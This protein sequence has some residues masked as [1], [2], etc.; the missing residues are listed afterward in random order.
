MSNY[1][2]NYDDTPKPKSRFDLWDMLSILVLVI[3]ACM[4]LYFVLIFL[5]PTS[6]LNPYPAV[7][8]VPNA[9]VTPTWTPIQLA[10]TW[11][12][13]P[14]LG[15]A[16]P[17]LVPT[18]TLEPS[19]TPLSLI[20]PSVTP[21]ATATPKRPFSATVTYIDSTIIHPDLACNWQGIGGS[22]VDAN[23]ADMAGLV[24]H[25]SGMYNGKTKNEPTVSGVAPAYGKSGYEFFLG[26]V[27]ISSKGGLSI[28]ILDQAGLPLSDSITIDT[29]NDCSKN[30][31]LV[32]FKKNP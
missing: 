10:A 28:Q 5:F 25:L 9:T 11:T 6:P 12:P 4:V 14:A 26:T 24:I 8:N 17:T 31:V 3:T 15:T 7:P 22:V 18:Q 16:T 13:T 2:Y 19:A 20:T 32:R 1:D 30:L 23:N 29:F 27:P 21:T